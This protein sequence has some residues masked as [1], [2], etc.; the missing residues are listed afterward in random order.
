M[1][2]ITRKCRTCGDTKPLTAFWADTRTT[3][4]W[5]FKQRDCKDCAKARRKLYYDQRFK[6]MR[7]GVQPPSSLTA[8]KQAQRAQFGEDQVVDHRSLGKHRQYTVDQ[9]YFSAIDTP[10]KAYWLGFL[11]ADGSIGTVN[12][13]PYDVR[14]EVHIRDARHVTALCNALSSTSP[15]RRRRNT[16]SVV[17]S[18]Q[19]LARDVSVIRPKQ[20]AT[21]WLDFPAELQVHFF[22]GA[23]DGDGCVSRLKKGGGERV[24]WLG[25]RALCESVQGRAPVTGRIAK[26]GKTNNWLYCVYFSGRERVNAL[27]TWLYHDA[28]AWLDRKYAKFMECSGFPALAGGALPQKIQINAITGASTPSL[29]DNDINTLKQALV[30]IFGIPDNTNISTAAM[31]MSST[32]LDTLKFRDVSAA[33]ANGGWLQRNG[34]ALSYHNGAAASDVVLTTLTQTLTN[35]TLTVPVIA[36]ISN[37]GT[38]TLP[39]STDTLVGRATTDTLTNK[40]LTNPTISG[41]VSGSAT[42]TTPTLSSP[43]LSSP[44]VSSLVNGGTLTLPS[45][46]DTLVGRATTDTLTNKTLTTPTLTTPVLSGTVT[47]TYTLGGTPT[48]PGA[49]LAGATCTQSPFTAN[50]ATVQAHGLGAIPHFIVSYLECLTAEANYSI[51]DRISMQL[52]VGA[53]NN[54]IV[55]FDATN[56]RIVTAATGAIINKT[57]PGGPTNITLAN[58]KVVAI[59][60]KIA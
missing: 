1:V 46:T 53:S 30:D 37:T 45:S 40:T 60:Y 58:W 41:T 10:D 54:W 23:F 52:T 14:V 2:C 31:L 11:F 39:T 44:V 4:R 57:A 19:A 32:G 33:A 24:E 55:E 6:Y 5:S 18:S 21:P 25:S 35:K 9:S 34:T 15:L 28:D 59:P 16:V 43:T 13:T 42:Y 7:V 26:K 36:T 56:V 49:C 38:L 50:T 29:I 48:I 17:F 3:Q 12:G 27:F 47:G 20:T 22:R 51:G 8:F